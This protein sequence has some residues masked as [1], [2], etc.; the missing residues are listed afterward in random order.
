[1]SLPTP[2]LD[3]RKAQELVDEAKLMLQRRWPDWTGWTD[4]NLSDP[5]V[6]LIEAFATMVE[7]LLYRMNRVPDRTYVKLLELA[8]LKL[9]PPVAASTPVTFWLSA[10]GTND[11]TV[12]AGTEVATDRADGTE[13]VVFR[14]VS[15]L[16]I[17]A[18]HA[19]GAGAMPS[20]G[21]F[22][23]L[24]QPL[25]ISEN[26]TGREVMLFSPRPAPDD[27]FYV[28]LSSAVPSCAVAIRFGG[29]VEGYGIDPNRPPR[30]WQARTPAGWVECDLERDE[31][32]GFNR[33][34][35]VVLHVPANHQM[36]TEGGSRRAGW[37]RC[38]VTPTTDDQP[39]YEASPRIESLEAFTVGGTAEAVHAHLIKREK[40]G[41]SEGVAGQQFN[42]KHRPVV[43]ATEPEVIEEVVPI[44]ASDGVAR[45]EAVIWTRTD[46]FADH[47]PDDRV[48]MIDPIPGVVRFGPAVRQDDG[49]VRRYG[50]VPAPGNEL[51]ADG[52]LTGGGRGGNVAEH[53]IKHLRESIA[54]IGSVDNRQLAVMGMDAESI[55]EAKVRGPFFLRTRDRAVTPS[56]FEHLAVEAA[57][58][59]ARVHCVHDAGPGAVRLLVVPSLDDVELAH[60]RPPHLTPTPET[61]KRIRDY[62]EERRVVGVSLVVEPPDLQ[63]ITVG[64]TIRA[65]PHASVDD[66]KQGALD[67]LYRYYHPLFGGPDG[68]GWPFGRAAVAGEVHAILR[69][70]AGVDL[71]E[72]SVLF[73]HDV[74]SGEQ[75]KNA[76]ERIE[77]PRNSLFLSVGH[78]VKVEAAT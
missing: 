24:T 46:S 38:V 3:D 69:G 5:G 21:E 22:A 42:L 28:G 44:A 62:L 4:H 72:E 78:K 1:V 70:V 11:V 61:L 49:S 51:I 8:G 59:V 48:F 32:G 39:A 16:E 75:H 13:P 6:T 23:D 34:G 64:A 9:H 7:Q 65:R 66:V 19:V 56:D 53:T 74:A 36:T 63:G 76:Q 73:A 31:T 54:G 77:L 52:Y 18:C 71:V 41:H 67:A 50:A 14:T 12:H 10:P 26:R 2:N 15:D 20:G 47:G 35:V 43:F 30:Q 40:I 45:S 58:E 57:P 29:K 68:G 25:A 55:E 60:L 17:V 27:A 37:L 33:Q